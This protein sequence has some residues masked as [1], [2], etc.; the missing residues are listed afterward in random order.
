MGAR[1]IW[2]A[3][4]FT[5]VMNASLVTGQGLQG[6]YLRG[7]ELLGSAYEF[8]GVEVPDIDFTVEGNYPTRYF[9]SARWSGSVLIPSAGTYWFKV[10]ADNGARMLLNGDRMIDC[11]PS[12]L[13]GNADSAEVEVQ[14]GAFDVV[15][16]YHQSTGDGYIRLSWK[17]PGD[18]DFSV[19]PGANLSP[20]PPESPYAVTKV[21][22][23]P[24]S[25]HASAMTGGLIT[26]SNLSQTTD[27]E[28]IGTIA[29]TPAEGQWTELTFPNNVAYRFV[30]YE[31]P[32]DSWGNVA[33]IEFY[34]GDT[35]LTG[36]VFGTAGSRDNSGNTFEKAMDGDVTTFF[37]AAEPHGQYVGIDLG[38]DMQAAAP[39]FSPT[40]GNFSGE[41]FVS[42]T[43][44]TP[45]TYIRYTTDGKTPTKDYGI[46]YDAP[47]PIAAT[48]SIEAKAFR[49]GHATSPSSVATYTVSDIPTQPGYRTFHVGNSL[50]GNFN[51]GFYDNIALSL[52]YQQSN[53]KHTVAGA[54]TD[55]IWN[56]T[57]GYVDK[58]N[59]QGP[60]DYIFTQPFGG[61][62]RSIENETE[63]SGKFFELARDSSPDIELR[64]YLQ[65][66]GMTY[67]D[68]W[69]KGRFSP[70]VDYGVTAATTWKEGMANHVRYF[71]IL[72]DSL[73]AHYPDKP[74]HIIPGGLVLAAIVDSIEAG[75]FPDVESGTDPFEYLWSDN[76]HANSRGGYAVGL[77][78][79]VCLYGE[80]PVG[81]ATSV[82]SGLTE[83]QVPVVQQIVWDVVTSY[84][85]S[86]VTATQRTLPASAPTLARQ[87]VTVTF[88]GRMLRIGGMQKGGSVALYDQ[89][90][91]RIQLPHYTTAVDTRVYGLQQQGLAK[92]VYV[93]RLEDGSQR[94]SRAMVVR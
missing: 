93:V 17:K 82:G 10:E 43:T 25:G 54:P 52:G 2:A 12:K 4:A 55:W 20:T 30:K 84:P 32:N 50:T 28:T 70:T 11:W 90:G 91:R 59:N 56:N 34:H 15:L 22:I 88:D 66:P 21:R 89:S 40:P 45:N 85:Y 80:N 29:N 92:G 73:L 51:P 9:W 8:G 71:E 77:T 38:T 87:A 81:R 47:F 67:D 48:T 13:G 83:A 19:I 26:G 27:F 64:L 36:E 49:P 35:K 44:T 31:A 78:H 69:C 68:A 58:L 16:E 75:S 79:V 62:G 5:L 41:V 33:E 37:D 6:V 23:Y 86:G 7:Q 60:F 39:Q 42:L 94:V 74:I 24:R 46:L 65:W 1:R 53:V 72:R 18:A 57:D 76:V 63:Y 61:H 14:S 3:L